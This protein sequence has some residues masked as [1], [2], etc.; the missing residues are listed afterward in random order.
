MPLNTSYGF[1][2]TDNG[3]QITARYLSMTGSA[4]T[5][6]PLYLT[7][8]ERLY[9]TYGMSLLLCF[10]KLRLT[11][12][13]GYYLEEPRTYSKLERLSRELCCNT[14]PTRNMRPESSRAWIDSVTG[15]R[16]RWEM[17]GLFFLYF[18]AMTDLLHDREQVFRDLC[19]NAHM[20]REEYAI[21][22]LECAD[23]VRFHLVDTLDPPGNLLCVLLRSKASNRLAHGSGESS[24]QIWVRAG[25]LIAAATEHDL[26]RPPS[27]GSQ[28]AL[29]LTELQKRIF[30]SA[31]GTACTLAAFHGRPPLITRFYI[32]SELPLDCTDEQL[33]NDDLE[34]IHASTNAE[35]WRLDGHISLATLSRATA[36]SN[37]FREE[38]LEL[39]LGQR[40][41]PEEMTT[42]VESLR[43]RS[44]AA[45][46]AIPV[47]A[48]LPLV[49]ESIP[50]L[51]DECTLPDVAGLQLR[52]AQNTFLLER[53][54]HPAQDKARHI[55]AARRM[56]SDV[57]SLWSMRDRFPDNMDDVRWW[58]ANNGIAS[59]SS[60]GVD[61]YQQV[62][63]PS[64][65][66]PGDAVHRARDITTLAKFGACLEWIDPRDG[67][68]TLCQN[69]NKM[70]QAVLERVLAPPE[71]NEPLEVADA[72][73][74]T[75]SLGA[76]GAGGGGV[77]GGM[78]AS[79]DFDLATVGLADVPAFGVDFHDWFNSDWAMPYTGQ[80]YGGLEI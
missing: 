76:A 19:P 75:P 67:N 60:L 71:A 72:S 39:S 53:I 65:A 13:K 8:M 9:D 1:R 24:S 6:K 35:G 7:F 22:T 33:L 48:K 2:Y 26:H 25:A 58:I 23:T 10:R 80:N 29:I 36:I 27:V 46:S 30:S 64:A 47:A 20:T 43:S 62:T 61:L 18:G 52:W 40:L 5:F 11:C 49:R 16:S 77:G 4:T 79:L 3:P 41:A 63:N 45:W 37:I 32:N 34:G 57:V 68:Y 54:A 28:P 73:A 59:F 42:R 55:A 66:A 17:I 38:I 70:L 15:P 69:A 44:E 21:R 31:F 50:A 12:R 56:L 74:G 14:T 51:G 78:D